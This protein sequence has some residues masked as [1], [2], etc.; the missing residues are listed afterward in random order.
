MQVY[1]ITG[2]EYDSNIYLV[3]G[4]VPTIIDTGTGFHSRTVL[5]KIHLYIRPPAIRQILLTH[6]HFDHVGGV[7]ELLKATQG[8]AN[9][10]GHKAVVQKLKEGKST[11][12]EMLGGTMP[13]ITVD[14]PVSDNERITIGDDSFEVL[15]TPGHSIGSLCLYGEKSRLLF[16][17]DTIF[18]QGGFGRYDFPGGN[19][20]SLHHSVERLASLDVDNLYP[21]HGPFVEHQGKDHILK[22]LRNIQ[23]LV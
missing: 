4:K 5:Q 16:S 7:P 22:A 9:I 1:V 19:L 10:I 8:N 6:E 23:S 18:A 2:M 3:T 13:S 15:A 12:A 20:G 11:F 14:I 17:G 21:G